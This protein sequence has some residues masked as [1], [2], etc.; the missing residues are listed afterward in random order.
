MNK[1]VDVLIFEAAW[2]YITQTTTTVK[3]NEKHGGISFNGDRTSFPSR[4]IGP[5][6][7][8]QRI[9]EAGY[10]CQIVSFVHFLNKQQLKEIITKYVGPKTVIGISSTF[11]NGRGCR[12]I[13]QFMREMPL[14]P[15]NK[16]II[17]GPS[18]HI[19]SQYYVL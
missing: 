15:T 4:F 2:S 18:A 17:G 8:S 10:T 5:S 13:A 11:A 6:K 12:S 14:T 9:R 3:L 19:C 16:T 1:P 7:I